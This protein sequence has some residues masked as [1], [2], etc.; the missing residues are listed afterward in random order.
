MMIINFISD[1]A[2]NLYFDGKKTKIKF[3]GNQGMC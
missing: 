1:C 2:D 3:D